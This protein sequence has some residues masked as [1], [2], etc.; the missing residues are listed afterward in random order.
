MGGVVYGS[1]AVIAFN[2]FENGTNTFVTALEIGTNSVVYRNIF[3][4]STASNS[5]IAIKVED[6]A[7]TILNN[8]IWSDLGTGGGIVVING[9]TPSIIMNNVIEGF[10]GTGGN[11]IEFITT[12]NARIYGNN[13]VEACTTEYVAPT[14][15]TIDDLSVS[16]WGGTNESLSA[17][18]FT[19]ATGGDFSPIDTDN[20]K[21][22]S[23]PPDFGDGQ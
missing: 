23:L 15:F 14:A 13:A 21:E 18:P 20:I 17:S 22:G 19:N 8:S 11:G 4:L 7:A 6:D 16:R 1:T 12:S 10:S 2:Y 5:S 3:H 9:V